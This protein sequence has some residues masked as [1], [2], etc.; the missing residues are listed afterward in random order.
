MVR[1][2]V[3]APC[4]SSPM[5]NQNQSRAYSFLKGGETSPIADLPVMFGTLPKKSR[6]EGYPNGIFPQTVLALEGFSL[7]L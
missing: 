5:L 2:Y 1:A 6:S 4:Q 3:P 7:I